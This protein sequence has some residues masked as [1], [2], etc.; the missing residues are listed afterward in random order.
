MSFDD[1][2]M[3]NP[4]IGLWPST[5]THST[6]AE[7]IRLGLIV[8]TITWLWVALVDAATGQAWHT[9]TALGGILPFTVAHYLLNV[10][11]GMI[12]LSVVHGAERAPSLIIG[13]IFCGL[14]FEG[15]FV[16]FSSI[17]IQR[18]LGNV[19]WLGIVGGNLIG[20]AVAITLLFRTHPV[21]EYVRRAEEET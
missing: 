2:T 7:G 3:T 1:S 4:L 19:G 12:L 11:Y 14:T 9:F 18:A 17:L 5:T 13:A 16:M 20:T 8:G 15:A 6:R 21:L 10:V